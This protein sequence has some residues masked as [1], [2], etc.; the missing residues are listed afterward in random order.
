M[1]CFYSVTAGESHSCSKASENPESCKRFGFGHSYN[2]ISWESHVTTTVW[3]QWAFLQKVRT[4]CIEHWGL[5]WFWLT[6]QFFYENHL[7][8]CAASEEKLMIQ[9]SPCL[10]VVGTFERA[11]KFAKCLV[12]EV[13]MTPFQAQHSLLCVYS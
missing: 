10:S 11:N 5:A 7:T 9:I 6:S 4:L 2:R 8:W 3:G 13:V 12:C 1:F